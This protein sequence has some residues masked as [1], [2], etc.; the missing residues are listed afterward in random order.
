MK[1]LILIAAMLFCGVFAFTTNSGANVLFAS[2]ASGGQARFISLKGI[3][4]K[5]SV[6]REISKAIRKRCF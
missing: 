3:T 6:F 5:T 4:G 2:A 1:R